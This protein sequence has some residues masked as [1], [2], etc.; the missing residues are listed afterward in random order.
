MLII[1]LF[2]SLLSSIYVY[3]YFRNFRVLILHISLL[4]ITPWMLD[5]ILSKPTIIEYILIK[6]INLSFLNILGQLISTD[7]IFFKSIPDMQYAVGSYGYFLPG[8]LPLVVFGFWDILSNKKRRKIIIAFISAI[9]ISFILVYY[10]G[11]FGAAVF[12]VFLSIFATFGCYK[13]VLILRVKKTPIF[14]KLLIVTI[15]LI[16]F[17]EILRLVHSISIQMKY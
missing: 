2:L 14:I 15:F 8:F 11:F 1:A 13:F 10:I 9:V 5:I 3:S 12:L 16:I 4:L 6:P 7:Y 17:Y